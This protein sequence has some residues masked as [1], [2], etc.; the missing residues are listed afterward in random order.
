YVL[1]ALHVIAR[2]GDDVVREQFFATTL[3][4]AFL[5]H[6]RTRARSHKRPL[7]RELAEMRDRL[8]RGDSNRKWISLSL[9]R[10]RNLSALERAHLALAALVGVLRSQNGRRRSPLGERHDE[11]SDPAQAPEVVRLAERLQT[12]RERDRYVDLP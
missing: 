11:R 10:L 3:P 12:A 8:P 6:A 7:A 9:A 1:A 2:P 4:A 5:D